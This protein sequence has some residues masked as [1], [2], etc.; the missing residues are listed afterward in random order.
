MSRRSDY[1][2]W[3]GEPS[4]AVETENKVLTSLISLLVALAHA[5]SIH[6]VL[7][8]PILIPLALFLPSLWHSLSLCVA[9]SL[10]LHIPLRLPLS[11]SLSL[12]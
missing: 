11:P 2:S 10:P 8:C 4:G 1:V 9:L 6:L 12:S 7:F 5:T 3:R